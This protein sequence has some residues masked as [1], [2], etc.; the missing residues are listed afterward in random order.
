MSR[1][2][3]HKQKLYALRD[4]ITNEI[5]YIGITKRYLKERLW[6]HLH[7]LSNSS[8]IKDLW[9]KD[10]ISKN[11]TP[12]I[13]LI[14]EIEGNE[15]PVMIESSEIKKHKNLL[16]SNDGGNNP[17]SVGGLNKINFSQE[18]INKLGQVPD[19]ELAEIYN[20]NKTTIARLRRSLSIPSY[21]K[22][23][24]ITGKFDGKGV[25]PRW[26]I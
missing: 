14:R 6:R 13:E 2:K 10:L 26:K 25:H 1:D 17:P 16:N 3:Y 22:T 7:P 19:Y 21:A 23:F 12:T 9:I 15:D 5:R 24:N 4:P 20:V 18:I 8:S 11:L